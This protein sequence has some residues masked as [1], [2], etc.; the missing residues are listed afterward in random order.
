M[1]KESG[2]KI[3]AERFEDFEKN[4]A[5]LSKKGHG[6]TNIRSNYIDIMFKAL[7]WN[8]KSHYEVVREFSQRDKSTYGGTKKVD[9][10]FKINGKLKFFLEAKEANV[11]LEQDKAAI[12]QAKRY[13]YSSNGK[14]P[15]VILTDFEEFRVFNVIKA[16]LMDNTD[17]ELLKSHTMRYTDYLKKWDLLWDTFSREAVENGSLDKLRGKIDKN[18]K[19]M[20]VDF[21]EQITGWR[22]LLAKNI[23]IRNENLNVDEINEAVQRIL[24]RLVFIRNLEDREI[25]PENTLL[26]K[27]KKSENIYKSLVPIFNSLNT[28]YNG[29]LFKKHFSEDINVDD[30]TIHEIIRQMNYPVSPF[31]FDVIE[32]EI[33]GRIYEKFLGSKIR[34]TDSHRAKIEEKPEVRHAGG[35][36]YTP[37][38]IVDYIVENTVGEKIKGL[39][40]KQIESIK[41]LDPACGSGSFLIGAYNY[42]LE[43]HKSWYASNQTDKEFKKDWFKSK[44]GDITININKRGEILVNNIF[45][46]DID[47]EATEVAIMS[48]YLKMLD[49]GFDRGERDLFFIKGAVLPDMTRNI[50]CG[51]TLIS[52]EYFDGILDKSTE[53]DIINPLDFKNEKFDVVIGNPPYVDSETMT[54][55]YPSQR[56]YLS[57]IYQSTKGNWDLYIPFIEKGIKLTEVGGFTSYITPNKW[58]SIDYGQALRQFVY[59]G[60]IQLTD[61]SKF[62]VF[63]DASIFPIVF[64]HKNADNKTLNIQVN[65]PDGEPYKTEI[66]K[67]EYKHIDNLGLLFSKNLSKIDQLISSNN[68]LG[69]YC[70]IRG[71]FTTSE[72]Y[73]LIPF[74]KEKK[75]LTTGYLKFVNTGTIEPL[76]TIWGYEKT[77]YLKTKYREPIVLI[78]DFK[79][80]FPKRY[81]RF[82]KP[83]II[84]SGIRHFESFLDMNCEYIAGKSTTVITDLKNY[85]Y[86]SVLAI[87]NSSLIKEFLKECYRSAGMDGGINYTPK[88]VSAIPLPPIED[89][90]KEIDDKFYSH[91]EEIKKAYLLLLDAKS[92]SEKDKLSRKIEM[93]YSSMDSLVNNLF[94]LK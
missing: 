86:H 70:E 65:H 21:L 59:K 51:N 3:I 19:T 4:K 58:L 5:I 17:R 48:L 30:K 91:V 9:Y 44:D 8:M 53:W 45:G 22:E 50:R 56:E 74:V 90:S 32:P 77:T 57:K 62:K 87:L 36:Y 41:I 43:Y 54:L 23:A 89:I 63:Q 13:A 42:L 60:L 94:G 20:D 16:P 1:N 7:G 33:L 18:T 76:H 78:S 10:A 68:Y 92:D 73:E 81:E 55:Y 88:I 93:L 26:D 84:I 71:A 79:K 37:E 14:A 39:T 64:I 67:N 11:D 34:L 40:P 72:A 80:A 29:L 6:E 2:K 28:T 75:S 24:D 69:N 27:T 47:R 31:Q 82:N 49:D 52:N 15:V 61:Y 66:D 25:E 38:Y 83:K 35:V 85:S 12:Y 46:I